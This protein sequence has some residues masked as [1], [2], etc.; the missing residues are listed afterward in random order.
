MNHVEIDLNKTK[1]AIT[2]FKSWWYMTSSCPSDICQTIIGIFEKYPTV[3]VRAM[4][5][6]LREIN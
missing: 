4:Q 1:A 5:H 3:V 2:G 6:A